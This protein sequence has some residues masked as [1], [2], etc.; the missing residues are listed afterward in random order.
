MKLVVM[1][2]GGTSVRSAEAR[3]TAALRVISAK[4]QGLWPVV[5]VSA[6]G[7]RGEPYAT[8]TLAELVRS[9]DPTVAPDQRE[10]DLVMSV[11][12][13][14]SA[15]VFAHTLK[16]LGYGAMALRGGQAGIRTDGV[17]GNARIVSIS[18]AG[19]AEAIA[20]GAIPVVCGFQGVWTDGKLPGA[21][22]TTLGR[23]GSDTTAAAIAAAVGAV[24][25]EIYT[26]VDGV[27]TAD[28]DFVPHA[29]TIHTISS[30][31]VA[32]IAHLGAKVLHPRAAEIAMRFGVPLWV[33]NTQSDH[34]GT[35]I[36][37]SEKSH[38]QSVTGVTHTGKLVH[39][40]FGLGHL[41]TEHR[42]TFQA[43]VFETLAKYGINVTMSSLGH[44]SLGF[45]VG[46]DQYADVKD[47]FDALVV[48]MPDRTVYLV[49]AGE[50]PSRAVETQHAL[51]S[52]L[53]SCETVHLDI[54]EGCTM[55][56]IVGRELVRNP[57]VFWRAFSILTGAG[58]PVLQTTDS[59]LS[60]SLLIPES[61]L[62][63]AVSL[64]HAA[65][66]ETAP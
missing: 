53:G 41:N 21:E 2:F 50:T 63:R 57:G 56:S 35:E 18:P 59:D 43:A 60:I 17:Y 29:P 1:K 40:Q 13:L 34:P 54:V 52:S 3:M 11:G 14:I 6:M 33:K 62:R 46:R 45:A 12:E 61:E 58:V 38:G 9:A 19:I 25:C 20:Q 31:E 5:V 66:A 10:M 26:D 32:E 4:E 23:G 48:P 44:T 64:L 51:M 36:I 16:G 7:R 42:R 30:L 37:P 55:V 47:I 8:D 22:L 65:F 39:F 28:P 15:V 49:Q 24:A 27:K